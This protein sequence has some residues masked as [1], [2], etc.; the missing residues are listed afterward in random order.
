MASH[1]A[2]VEFDSWTF[3][4]SIAANEGNGVGGKCPHQWSIQSCKWK[5][6]KTLSMLVQ[7]CRDLFAIVKSAGGAWIDDRAPRIGAALAFYTALSLSPLLMITISIAGLIYGNEAA[8]GGIAQQI[9]GQIG[10]NGA[11]AIEEIL[12]N[13]KR[14]RSGIL[15]LVIG[16]VT[17]FIGAM[18]V[19]GELQDAMNDIWKVRTRKR[20]AIWNFLRA[21]FLSFAMVL[22]V[23]FLLLVSLTLTTSISAAGAHFT[24]KWPGFSVAFQVAN[25]A[26]SFIIEFCL[27]GMIFKVL[28]D[29]ELK[30]RDVAIGA[31]LTT[32]LFNIGKYLIVLYMGITSVGSSFGA[33]GSLIALLV[34]IYYSTQIL[35]FGAEVTRV[36]AERGGRIIAAKS[37][38]EPIPGADTPVVK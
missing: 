38:A 28:P 29:A 1:K 31:L 11:K 18:G 20:R 30:W 34:W 12:A 25:L 3:Q 13:S 7:K 22:V 19:F 27:F 6:E 32:V 15:A 23:G 2:P 33:A 24:A 26:V 21:R 36:V 35:L 14:E 8:Q 9:E 17:L 4:R 37:G 5:V 16:A 10:P